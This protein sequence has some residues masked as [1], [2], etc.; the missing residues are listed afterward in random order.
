MT[1]GNIVFLLHAHLPYVRHPENQRHLEESWYFEAVIESYIPLLNLMLK[2]KSIAPEA[3]LALSI[4]PTL[5]EMISDRVLSERLIAH[6]DGLIELTEHEVRRTD[7][8]PHFAPITEMYL[9]V[10][11]QARLTLLE[12]YNGSLLEPLIELAGSDNIELITTAATHA[13]LPNLSPIPEAVKRQIR[14]GLDCFESHIGV[15]PKGFWLPES[16]YYE[17][18]D[19]ILVNEGI[20]HTFLS[21]RGLLH[22]TPRPPYGLYRPVRTKNGLIAFG[23]EREL[24]MRIWSAKT[25][26]PANP[27]Y[28]DFYRDAGFDIDAPHIRKYLDGITPGEK[29]Y[30]GLKYYKVT[31]QT[32][33]KLPYRP[34]DAEAQTEEDAL[35]FIKLLIGQA[36]EIKNRSRFE[37]TFTLPF[38]AELFGHWWHE[39][40]RWLERFL[41][42][43]SKSPELKMLLPGDHTINAADLQEASPGLS[44]WG[45]G[46]YSTTWVDKKNKGEALRLG[47]LM[48]LRFEAMINK[49]AQSQS[50]ARKQA[51][52]LAERE[53]LMLQSSDWSFL[54]H[55]ETA[56]HYAEN[57]IRLHSANLDALFQML[58][59]G[60]F[61]KKRLSEIN[62][63]NPI[64]KELS[65]L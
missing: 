20:T 22:S 56:A 32:D 19:R 29:T 16:G 8:D 40:P 54:T 64:F 45:E 42:L 49:S 26:Y 37:P 17:N 39:G 6:M 5:L 2:L 25:G 31:G 60:E 48:S 44:S 15:R 21:S 30:T 61:D 50:P 36:Q 52:A 28:R 4:S 3:R 58:N 38:D 62:S 65:Q 13:Y 10:L 55:N 53:L 41:V 27:V 59:T 1:T 34:E 24:S 46:G 9:G 11:K 23:R 51:I 18:L 7:G 33:D 57:R 12:S 63:Q 14:T 47:L 35:D 43:A